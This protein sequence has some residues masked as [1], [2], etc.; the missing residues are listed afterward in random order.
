M[1]PRRAPDAQSALASRLPLYVKFEL[2]AVTNSY[3]MRESAVMI[4][5]TTPSAKYSCSDR[6]RLAQ[7]SRP[8][9]TKLEQAGET[10]MIR[11][12]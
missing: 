12:A 5:S 2:R 1:D 10:R 9:G 7:L 4:S 3:R 11:A 8:F 6:D